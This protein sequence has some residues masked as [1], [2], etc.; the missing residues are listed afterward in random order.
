MDKIYIYHRY[1]F[2]AGQI[3]F[4]IINIARK[5]N[6][7][8]ITKKIISLFKYRSDSNLNENELNVGSFTKVEYEIDKT[9]IHT[10]E[11]KKEN[12]VAI[13]IGSLGHGG[14]EK[15]WIFLAVGL[16][17]LG[18]NP[19][20]FIQQNLNE[21]SK[22]YLNFLDQHEINIISLSDL[23]DYTDILS[24]NIE[25]LNYDF[26]PNNAKSEF[27]RLLKD[28]DKILDVTIRYFAFRKFQYLFVAL[29]Y[30]NIFFGISALINNFPNILLSFRS[31]SPNYY[32]ENNFAKNL[33][34]FIYTHKSVKSSANSEHVIVSYSQYFDSNKE[35]RLTP[36]LNGIIYGPEKEICNCDKFHIV[37]LLRFSREKGPMEWLDAAEYV[38]DSVDY[39]I[40]FILSGQGVLLDQVRTRVK[41]L[42]LM[43]LDI[44]LTYIENSNL[45]FNQTSHGMLLTSSF[46]EG[47][48][49]LI[50][51]AEAFKFP[52]FSLFKTNTTSVEKAPK[53]TYLNSNLIDFVNTHIKL[54]PAKKRISNINLS[55]EELSQYAQQYLNLFQ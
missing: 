25:N 29:D 36:N 15:Q 39:K 16:K 32:F 51:E 47:S 11:S 5:F 19:I 37:G 26:I 41:D 42:K 27:S 8:N 49:N 23:R 55:R 45:I 48:S 1:I 12:D 54:V 28:E 9:I 17:Y 35:I 22:T 38:H 52:Y 3:Y 21:A 10:S 14:A 33:Y 2:K 7:R 20:F 24:T 6:I 13:C 50:L 53:S 30:A 43:G 18:Y 46:T 4:R 34:N 31:L 44:D 40:H